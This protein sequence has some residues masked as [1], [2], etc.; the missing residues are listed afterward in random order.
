MC[1][2]LSANIYFPVIPSIADDLSTTVED[3]NISVTV[4]M[5]FQGI[6]PSFMGAI[7][8]VLGRR[9]VYILTFIMCVCPCRF[10]SMQKLLVLI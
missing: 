2:P 3:I 6:S 5:V 8:D 7:C 10:V 4:Y 1:S 9:P